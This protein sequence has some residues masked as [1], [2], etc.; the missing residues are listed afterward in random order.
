[1]GGVASWKYADELA[2][3]L[4]ARYEAGEFDE[5]DL[6]FTHFQSA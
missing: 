6:I 4:M 2:R 5:V 1:M 3:N